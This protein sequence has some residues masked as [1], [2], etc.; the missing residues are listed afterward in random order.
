MLYIMLYKGDIVYRVISVYIGLYR[1]M[2]GEWK[3]ERKLLF[4][5][6]ESL[7]TLCKGGRNHA[8]QTG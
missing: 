6:I 5:W 3:R 4:L 1:V 7:W 2:Q 8:W